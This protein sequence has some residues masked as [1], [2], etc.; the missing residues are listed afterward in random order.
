MPRKIRQLI[1]DYRPAPQHVCQQHLPRVRSLDPAHFAALDA[2]CFQPLG[3]PVRRLPFPVFPHHLE[4]PL[5]SR[6]RCPR[7]LHE[8]GGQLVH[9]L[10]KCLRPPEPSAPQMAATCVHLR[11]PCRAPRSASSPRSRRACPAAP[12]PPSARHRVLQLKRSETRLRREPLCSSLRRQGITPRALCYMAGR[13]S[14][15]AWRV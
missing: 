8:R 13:L 12:P 11:I 6:L 4:F 10:T 3:H 5:A 2:C 7:F 1:T 15:R 14:I 9:L